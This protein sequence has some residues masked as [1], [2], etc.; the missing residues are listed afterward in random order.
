MGWIVLNCGPMKW[1][2]LPDSDA[3]IWIYNCRDPTI[4]I[5]AEEWLFCKIIAFHIFAF[6]WKSKLLEND[7]DLWRVGTS[8]NIRLQFDR[9]SIRHD[10][11]E[12]LLEI[13]GIAATAEVF[14][15][16]ISASLRLVRDADGFRCR[17]VK[18][19]R[20]HVSEAQTWLGKDA[21]TDEHDQCLVPSPFDF[22]NYIHFSLPSLPEF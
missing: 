17:D 6:I 13:G 9:L 10:D 1:T 12:D 20:N 21:G 14:M 7:R 15:H 16:N 4:G 19:I 5:N 3:C 2:Y 22:G 18:L 11:A 8:P